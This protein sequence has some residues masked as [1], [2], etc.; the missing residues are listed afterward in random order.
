MKHLGPIAAIS[1][2]LALCPWVH[3]TT[4]GP[5]AYGYIASDVSYAWEDATGGQVWLATADDQAATRSLGFTFNF[6]GVGY[7]L[8]RFSD[9]GL[10]TFVNE[11]TQESNGN[12][13]TT[14]LA[15][16][17][18]AIAVLWDDWYRD[19]DVTGSGVYYATV[20]TPGDR[21][22]ILQW[23]CFDHA[24]S[25][26][27]TVTFQAILYEAT[28]SVLCQYQDVVITSGDGLYDYG[29]SAT[30]GIR[31]TAGQTSGRNL[32]WSFNQA[33]IGNGTSILFSGPVPEPVTMAGLVLGIG[34]LARYVRRRRVA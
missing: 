21:R 25:T 16:D 13:T 14:A 5:D 26:P 22:F 1:M 24:S 11:S 8:V 27:D 10:I 12:L 29:K 17:L 20:G 34:C 4:I 23:N 30:V 7:N 19:P 9:N 15:P 32:Q 2:M 3:A 18:P 28:G 33:V 31:D 6:Y